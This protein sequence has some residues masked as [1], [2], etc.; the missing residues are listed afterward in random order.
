MDHN[1]VLVFV[2]LH[3]HA[4]DPETFA[5]PRSVPLQTQT[6]AW[7]QARNLIADDLSTP[8]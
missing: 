8:L 3:D 5:V 1:L 4:L 6:G 2:N 7:Y